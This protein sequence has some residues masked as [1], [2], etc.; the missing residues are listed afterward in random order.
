MKK[1]LINGVLGLSLVVGLTGC[2]QTDEEKIKEILSSGIK[3]IKTVGWKNPSIRINNLDN[4]CPKILNKD[5]YDEK[6]LGGSLEWLFKDYAVDKHFFVRDDKKSM[7]SNNN[8]NY[9][10]YKK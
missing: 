5:N 8:C 7:F 9:N 4:H 1:M 3:P 6:K 10:I 2:G